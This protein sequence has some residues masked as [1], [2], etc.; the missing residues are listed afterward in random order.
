MKL[1]HSRMPNP[2]VGVH[3]S[4]ISHCSGRRPIDISAKLVSSQQKKQISALT[5]HPM[6]V[7][8]GACCSD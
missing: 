5:D 4:L 1:P 8:P 7:P 2:G 6:A 3:L